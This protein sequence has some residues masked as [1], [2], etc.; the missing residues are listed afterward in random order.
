MR[1]GSLTSTFFEYSRNNFDRVIS[2]QGYF[3]KLNIFA[4]RWMIIIGLPKLY[5]G[6]YT[7]CV[8]ILI[9]IKRTQASYISACTLTSTYFEVRNGVI[10]VD[11][12]GN[13]IAHPDN[14]QRRK[15]IGVRM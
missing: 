1:N 12:L 13:S 8:P 15:T 7:E 3:Q 9:D 14:E 11:N 10:K 2:F 5:V 6:I 4:L